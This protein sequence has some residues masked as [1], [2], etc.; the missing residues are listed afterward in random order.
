[1]SK[2]VCFYLTTRGLSGNSYDQGQS[3]HNIRGIKG[4]V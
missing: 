2:K 1:M 4:T 3:S